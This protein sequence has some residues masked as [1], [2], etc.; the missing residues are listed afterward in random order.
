[1]LPAARENTQ[2]YC[3]KCPDGAPPASLGVVGMLIFALLTQAA[4]PVGQTRLAMHQVQNQE[5]T[6]SLELPVSEEVGG[7]CE[8]ATSRSPRPE[9]TGWESSLAHCATDG[10][11]GERL[12]VRL[13]APAE[14]ARRKGTGG[15][16]RC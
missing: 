8:L 4:W 6:D 1:M 2:N 11:H 10:N 14:H 16:L 13:V 7:G 12:R 15:P 9:V 3:K 5:E